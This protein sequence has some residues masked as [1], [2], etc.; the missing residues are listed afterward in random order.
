MESATHKMEYYDRLEDTH[1]L[2]VND[3]YDAKLILI[4]EIISNSEL[5]S[6]DLKDLL[7]AIVDIL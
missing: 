1:S 6:M 4:D 2:S 3:A 7:Q 5:T